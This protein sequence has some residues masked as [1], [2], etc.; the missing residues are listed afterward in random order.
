MRLR[1]QGQRR[2][3]EE[4]ER[5]RR[6]LLRGNQQK[7]GQCPL[8]VVARDV[9][10]FMCVRGIQSDTTT[11][12]KYKSVLNCNILITRTFLVQR[13]RFGKNRSRGLA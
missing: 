10:Y 6:D 12:N 3:E 2:L 8:P 11:C 9:F 5:V 1:A 13:Y 4:Q 7:S